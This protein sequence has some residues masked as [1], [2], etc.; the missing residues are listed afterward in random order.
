ME[1]IL[2]GYTIIGGLYLIFDGL[3]HLSGI[4]LSSVSGVWPQSALSYAQ[5]LN[6]IYASF[7]IFT[8]SV[9]F[10]IQKDFKKYRDILVLLSVWSILHGLI[11]L[12]LVLT[13]NYQE[14]FRGLPSILV[15]LPFYR[16]YL[17]FN[18]LLLFGYSGVIYKYLKDARS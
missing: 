11:L 16:H 18:V 9:G 7:V 5:L 2:R 10:V 15:W 4:K 13:N 14:I 8:A 17:T 3:L 1:K 12:F 6:F